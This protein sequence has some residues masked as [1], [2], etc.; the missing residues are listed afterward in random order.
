MKSEIEKTE[1]VDEMVKGVKE[2][3]LRRLKVHKEVQSY[4]NNFVR[5]LLRAVVGW[6]A[7]SKLCISE[8]IEIDEFPLEM[9]K[10]FIRF[11]P[12]GDLGYMIEDIFTSPAIK[13]FLKE[14][15]LK[16]KIEEGD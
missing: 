4:W 5:S 9:Q 14:M 11:N 3:R 10:V 1:E 2:E 15:L 8:R 13:E 7:Y 12:K 6:E 16:N